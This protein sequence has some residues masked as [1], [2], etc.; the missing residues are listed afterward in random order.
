MSKPLYV[1]SP[2]GTS[3][4]TNMARKMEV[5]LGTILKH[6]NAKSPL[7]APDNDKEIIEKVISQ[8]EKK[9][10]KANIPTVSEMSAELHS[11]IKLYGGIFNSKGDFHQLLS[12]D[13]WLGETT[14]KL[15]ATWLENKG[16]NVAVRRQTDL[17]TKDV[18]SFQCAMAELVSWLEK[19]IPPMQ[20]HYKIIFNLT[21]G[22]K[23]VQGFLQTLA[24]FYADESIYIFEA[25]DLLKIPRLPVKMEVT[26]TIRSNLYIFRRLAMGL[27]V[28]QTGD[29]PETLLMT[30]NGEI[31]LSPWG[32][33][34]WERTK[35]AIYKEKMF[36]PPT[37]K[38]IF[39]DTFKGSSNAL[40]SDRRVILNERIDQ[41]TR[42][43]E[44]RG[45]SKGW[46]PGSLDFKKL[47]GNPHPPSTHECDAWA[48]QDAKRIFCHFEQDVLVLDELGKGLGH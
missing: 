5:N 10:T 2:C 20:P 12:T 43:I 42:Y 44:T 32:E 29:I 3:L 39:S 38:I 16:F 46:N 26:D 41:L 7:E 18:E 11:I 19:T 24:S 25:G 30:I 40:S 34:M 27:S 45:T 22:F 8:V 48:D 17:Q 21:G 9:L 47:K 23:T 36:P 35:K 4:L 14:S 28:H 33:L 1:F 15:V 37:E 31:T 13:T 6:S